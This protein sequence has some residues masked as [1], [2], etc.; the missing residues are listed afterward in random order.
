M[1]IP[2]P[3]CSNNRRTTMKCRRMC[4]VKPKV[5]PVDT[6]CQQRLFAL[7]TKSYDLL[8]VR[9]KMDEANQLIWQSRKK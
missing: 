7:P 3:P 8:E 9:R 2:V 5:K 4:C 6:T 1:E